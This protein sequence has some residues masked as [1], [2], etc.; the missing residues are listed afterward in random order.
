MKNFCYLMLLALSFGFAFGS[1][2]K[3]NFSSEVEESFEQPGPTHRQG[4]PLERIQ[5][6]S[7]WL[8]FVDQDHYNAV[9]RYLENVQ[10]EALEDP[11]YTTEVVLR[12][13]VGDGYGTTFDPDPSLAVLEQD[14]GVYTL[15]KRLLLE[16]DEL[17]REGQGLEEVVGLQDNGISSSVARTLHSADFV[18]QIGNTMIYQ[19]SKSLRVLV[20]NNVSVM[21]DIIA[22]GIEEVYKEENIDFVDL[23]VLPKGFRSDF[24]CTADFNVL[25]GGYTDGEKKEALKSF[26]WNNGDAS[27]AK[28]LQLTWD[29]GD[30]TTTTTTNAA[31]S[32]KYEN[33]QPYPTVNTFNVCVT[34]TYKIVNEEEDTEELC[35]QSACKTVTITLPEVEVEE[36][37]CD[38][39]QAAS[40]LWGLIGSPMEFQP[41]PNNAQQVCATVNNFYTMLINLAIADNYSFR[42]TFQ[43]QTSSG[44]QVCFD[45]PCDGTYLFSLEIL[46]ADGNLCSSYTDRYNHNVDAYCEGKE[47][48]EQKYPMYY[49]HNGENKGVLLR[50]KHETNKDD[51]WFSS[52]PNQV[53]TEMKHYKKVNNKWKKDERHNRTHILGNVYPQGN[54]CDC[55]GTPFMMDKI[56]QELIEK[57]HKYERNYVVFPSHDDDGQGIFCRVDDP[58]TVEFNPMQ[59]S[60][61]LFSETM[62]FPF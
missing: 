3:D 48:I 29:W 4:N 54:G 42:W 1:C 34:A 9:Y 27:G 32:H 23:E 15:R 31:A 46:D 21:E 28:D 44:L 57:K 6:V 39:L 7:S 10:Q 37:Y 38:E 61:E 13:D 41:T 45:A 40:S 5:R 14:F 26:L 60:T 18:I 17:L 11:G 20:D 52:A 47:D 51:G 55:G 8:K 35:S 16:E 19:H 43:G 58:Y 22:N 24:P 33:L 36:N 62:V 49:I 25:E 56:F 59:S 50:G 53:E 2:N 30:G 12:E